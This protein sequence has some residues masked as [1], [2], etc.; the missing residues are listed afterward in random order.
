MKSVHNRV[1][2][3]W[4]F[5]KEIKKEYEIRD[6]PTF[7]SNNSLEILAAVEHKQNNR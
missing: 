2:L 1:P 6:S 3:T 4:G 5:D 7:M